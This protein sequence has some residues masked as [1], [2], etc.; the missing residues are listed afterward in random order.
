MPPQYLELSVDSS[1]NGLEVVVNPAAVPLEAQAGDLIAI[2][3]TQEH[4]DLV[5]SKSTT[6]KPC[7]QPP[8]PILYTVPEADGA[9][10]DGTRMSRIRTTTRGA[11]VVSAAIAA[12]FDWL[13]QN[14]KSA[15]VTIRVVSEFF[16]AV[17]ALSSW[18]ETATTG[19]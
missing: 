2:G 17:W 9:G 11:V 10:E 1:Y 7:R 13:P 15:Q 4:L 12:S 5:N 8:A 19:E 3:P 16:G 6:G 18:A 14:Q